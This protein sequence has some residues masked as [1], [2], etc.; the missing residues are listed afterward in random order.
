MKPILVP[1]DFSRCAQNAIDFAVKIAK[2][3]KAEIIILHA[4][5][6][7]AEHPEVSEATVFAPTSKEIHERMERVIK[8]Q[9]FIHDDFPELQL[10]YE[11]KIDFAVDAIITTA[12]EN[13]AGMIVMGTQ[14]ATNLSKY[15]LGSNTAKVI[16]KSTVPV[17]AIPQ[18]AKFLGFAKIVFA[19]DLHEMDDYSVFDTLVE[20]ALMFN[21]K[22]DIVTVHKSE[23]DMVNYYELF[24]KVDIDKVFR[25]AKIPFEFHKVIHKDIAQGIHDF[26]KENHAYLLVTMPEKHGFIELLFNNSITRKLVFH[27]DTAVLTLPNKK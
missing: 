21:S 11:I 12:K 1:T 19:D 5:K 13:N 6:L 4:E 9:R 17:L 27:N 3:T 16:N 2:K 15:L 24:E 8:H 26:V 18:S 22:I 14:G 7:I 10:R 20:I 23:S 25:N